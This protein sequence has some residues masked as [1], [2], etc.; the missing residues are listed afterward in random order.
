MLNDNDFL[1]NIWENYDDYLQDKN[2][3]KYKFF[4]KHVY[5]NTDY[6]IKLKTLSTLVVTMVLM[7]TGV[8]GTI[9]AYN[10]KEEIKQFFG[11][12]NLQWGDENYY[13][14]G[15]DMEYDDEDVQ[16][17]KVTDY[18]E[19]SKIKKDWNDIVDMN[20]EDFQENFVVVL[21]APKRTYI[22]D[23]YCEEQKTIIEISRNDINEEIPEENCIISTKI[24]NSLNRENIEIT[25]NPNL[26]E[27]T[28]CI[29]AKDITTDYTIEMA[30]E[31]GCFVIDH[32]HLV[33][34]DKKQID[35]FMENVDNN[36]NSSIRIVKFFKS[37]EEELMSITDI[38]YK[39]GVCELSNYDVTNKKTICLE[40]GNK[41]I[42][43]VIEK[44]GYCYYF[45]VDSEEWEKDRRS[46]ASFGRMYLEKN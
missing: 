2:G 40:R 3:K 10:N 24:S 43:N 5:K 25:V 7:A 30:I 28:E 34:E 37:Y 21:V 19:Y 32:G 22:S 13:D 1:N 12:M 35:K 15:S 17:K 36:I 38:V 41:I 44:G 23:I 39:D 8:Y 20:E 26:S 16:Y 9:A 27:M 29:P 18:A 33:S 6:T 14:W 42:K 46:R 11:R 45:L 4:K 31:D